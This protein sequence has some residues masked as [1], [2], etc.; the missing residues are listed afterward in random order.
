VTTGDSAERAGAAPG[1]SGPDPA[2]EDGNARR[3]WL[4]VAA[5]VVATLVVPGLIY[6]RPPALPFRL[7]FL[8]LPLVPAVL[9]GAVA[10]YVAVE[11]RRA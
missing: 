6:L 3:E 11:S 9:L 10:V 5:V 4:L 2:E 7:A 1:G 8:V